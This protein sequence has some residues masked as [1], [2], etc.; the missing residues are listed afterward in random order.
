MNALETVSEMQLLTADGFDDALIGFVSVF[1][2]T[3]A[4]Y[5]RAKCIAVL[6]R[7]GRMDSEQAEEFLE[8]NVIGAYVGEGTPA[9]AT[10][11]SGPMD[12]FG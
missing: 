11:I 12:I 7:G 9:F 6:M 10:I 2:R 5:D 1:N 8:F 3:V 4:L